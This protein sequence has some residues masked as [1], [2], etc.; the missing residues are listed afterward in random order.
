MS[1]DTIASLQR[2]QQLQQAEAAAGDKLLLKRE[3]T[4]AERVITISARV[5][6]P[7][8]LGI[9]L[10]IFAIWFL[11]KELTVKTYLV[12]NIATGEKFRVDRKDFKQ[13]K[14]DC[15]TKEK[16]VKKISDL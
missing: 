1:Y 10:V 15:K 16:E 6:I 8:T 4:T 12:K 11:I 3:D 2:M 5:L 7:F 13:Y 9:S 14:K